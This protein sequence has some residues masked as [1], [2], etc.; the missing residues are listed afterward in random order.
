[1][2]GVSETSLPGVGVRYD[3]PTR[4]GRSVGVVA[5]HTGRRDLVV[6]EERDPA[7][8]AASV[9]LSE[10]EAHTLGELLGGSPIIERLE[11][12]TH[13]LEDLEIAWVRIEESSPVAGK[14]LGQASLRS[15]TG[16]GVVALVGESASVPVP[17]GSEVLRVGEMAVVVGPPDAVAAV[18]ELLAPET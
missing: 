10:D 4:S 16:A 9:E 11:T 2:Q 15:R 17:G 7:A 13:R 3:L 6:Y 14:T 18:S 5:H 8:A 1:M 12:L